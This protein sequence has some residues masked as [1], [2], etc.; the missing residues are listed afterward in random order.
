MASIHTVSIWCL[1]H[2][3]K[4]LDAEGGST[5]DCHENVTVCVFCRRVSTW[6]VTLPTA[7][8]RVREEA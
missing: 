4:L 3:V 5:D 8:I 1:T 6:T 2:S 7:P